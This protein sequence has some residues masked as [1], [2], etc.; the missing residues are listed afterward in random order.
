[1]AEHTMFKLCAQRIYQIAQVTKVK[2]TGKML[3][4]KSG[5]SKS[6]HTNTKPADCQPK[7]SQYPKKL[8]LIKRHSLQISSSAEK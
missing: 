5:T 8:L 4:N 6:K 3:Q 1:M 7:I 2:N